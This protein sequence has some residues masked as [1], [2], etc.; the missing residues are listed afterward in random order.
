MA[1]EITFG[2]GDRVDAHFDGHVLATDQDGSQPAPFDLFLASIGTC[3]GIYVSRFCRKR[4]IST[5]GIRLAQ[6]E[7][8][9][10]Q[11][12]MV[13]R[14][15]LEIQLPRDFPD[16]YRDAVVRVAGLCTVKK[17]LEAPPALSVRTGTLQT[18]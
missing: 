2:P 4:G 3:A 15:D 8:V 12:G 7:T 10:E 17:H 5:E 6:S 11:S 14:I 1:M 9:D 18:V 13:S 16:A